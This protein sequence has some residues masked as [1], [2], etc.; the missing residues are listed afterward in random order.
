MSKTISK[1]VPQDV[2]DVLEDL[3]AGLGKLSRHLA[4]DVGDAPSSKALALAH[5]AEA[6]VEEARTRSAD[7]G[8]KAADLSDKAVAEARAHPA[9]TAALAAAAVALIGFV[10]TRAVDKS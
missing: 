9:A 10:V 5:A 2:G 3:S 1:A 7:L 6:L 8:D 4:D